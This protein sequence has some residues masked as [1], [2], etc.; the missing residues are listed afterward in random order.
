M[1]GTLATLLVCQAIGE[2]L[3]FA[4]RLPI[5]GPVLGMALLLGYLSLSEAAAQRLRPT[6]LAL[7]KHLSL[8]FVPAGVG[9]MLHAAR[10]ADEWLAIAVALI[11]STA[12][13]VVVTAL[14]VEASRRWLERNAARRNE[15]ES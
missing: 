8:L 7:L 15:P 14:V 10:L 2:A 9:V 13:A 3:S 11:V 4:L 1:I 12:L 6:C 5:P